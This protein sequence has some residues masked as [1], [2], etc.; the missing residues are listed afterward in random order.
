EGI[1]KGVYHT[2]DV[3]YDAALIFG[4]IS[5]K[6]SKILRKLKLKPQQYFLA[7]VHR[8][9]NTNNPKRLKS[10]LNALA[11]INKEIPVVLPLHP[12]TAK[13]IT[14]MNLTKIIQKLCLLPPLSFLD[15]MAL[16]K[17]AK[18]IITDSGGIQKEAYFHSVPCI[19][20]REETEW[21]ETVNAE[22]NSLTGAD[23]NKI[24]KAAKSPE[25]G[26]SIN[27]YGTGNAANEIVRI[28]EDFN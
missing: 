24:I 1:F 21:I 27:E 3:M 11:V 22:W 15:M 14:N 25:I 17:K 7:T 20:L 19:T 16:E 8:A 9:E 12:G 4:K 2:G 23:F 10:I 13:I 26:K 6:K 18:V 5:E 28:L